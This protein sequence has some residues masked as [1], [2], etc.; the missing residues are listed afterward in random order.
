M[1]ALD[2]PTSPT[3]GQTYTANGKSW[4]W[5]GTAWDAYPRL[6]TGTASQ[7]LAND[8]TGS[9][10]NVTV[11][12]GLTYS[13]NTLTATG[14]G[15]GTTVSVSTI[16][17]LRAVNKLTYQ[18]AYVEGYYTA[19]DGGGGNY[20]Y[21]VADTSS[22]DNGGTIIVATDGGRWKLSWQG[23]LSVKQFGAY[24]NNTNAATTTAAFQ[25]ALTYISTV[26]RTATLFVP[27]GE[28]AI[29]ST[30]SYTKTP[31]I[32]SVAI[33]GEDQNKTRLIYS[34]TGN[35]F[36]FTI[37][38]SANYSNAVTIKNV[39]LHTNTAGAGTAISVSQTANNFV[40]PTLVIEDVYINQTTGAYW[41]TGI[42]TA[43]IEQQYF[44]RVTIY[45]F[46]YDSAACV[47]INNSTTVPTFGAFF[48]SCSFNGAQYGIRCVGWIESVY[49]TDSLL[50]GQ[51]YVVSC[52]ATGVAAG[53]PHFVA[54]STHLNATINTFTFLK[55]R[56]IYIN[57]C[58]V[59]SGVGVLDQTGTNVYIQDAAKVVITGCGI[60]HGAVDQ[61]R[62]HIEFVNVVDFSITGNVMRNSTNSGIVVSG[63]SGRGT[64]SG[65]K[66]DGYAGLPAVGAGIY[67]A[68]SFGLVSITGNSF[69]KYVVGLTV[70]ASDN[71]ISANVF[72]NMTTG[73]SIA[74]GS[75]NIITGNCY[76]NVTN[77]QL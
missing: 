29:N 54:T 40:A 24:S 67:L 64:I 75:N 58:D 15:S 56:A 49:I 9:F 21:D 1:A 59:Y 2:F 39:N 32:Y 51:R 42:T 43:N 20:Y 38:T 31:I 47:V 44:N 76:K 22:A 72:A 33:L 68:A 53:C 27:S 26:Q 5:N 25:S 23:Q 65:N 66:I 28:Y 12:S 30:L 69:D 37:A 18:F 3:L 63:T 14:G 19:G 16:A 74:S 7:L 34:G 46:G 77:G 13:A 8:G 50:V 41:T 52:D 61:L 57:N 70:I 55:W 35:L 4:Q 48:A 36:T 17:T 6:T 62:R 10:A 45:L 71:A 11:G 60:E 73:I